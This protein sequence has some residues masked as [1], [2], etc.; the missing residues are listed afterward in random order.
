VV[1]LGHNLER[2][3]ED[4]H[5][6]PTKRIRRFVLSLR[7]FSNDES[8]FLVIIQIAGPIVWF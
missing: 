1:G 2:K 5:L 8:Y 6:N 4:Q 3:K 7:D